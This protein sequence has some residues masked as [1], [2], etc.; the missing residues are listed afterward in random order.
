MPANPREFSRLEGHQYYRKVAAIRDD[1]VAVP[2]G[3]RPTQIANRTPLGIGR[4]LLTK[5]AGS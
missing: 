3:Q 5:S 4:W 1:I 2:S